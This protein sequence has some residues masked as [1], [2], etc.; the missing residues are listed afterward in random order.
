MIDKGLA[1]PIG[2]Y[3]DSKLTSTKEGK[4]IRYRT[5]PFH[6]HSRSNQLR[7]GFSAINR[8]LQRQN[9]CSS[10]I[11]PPHSFLGMLPPLARCF[12]PF[13]STTGTKKK[14]SVITYIRKRNYIYNKALSKELANLI[15]RGRMACPPNLE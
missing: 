5:F 10:P 13:D 3:S 4:Y 1:L 11:N 6:I 9:K 2:K 12:L 7:L 14:E 8:L 15:G